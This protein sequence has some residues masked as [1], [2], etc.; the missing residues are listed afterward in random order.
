[1]WLHTDPHAAADAD[2]P[3]HA[4]ASGSAA[5]TPAFFIAPTEP[6]DED[7]AR[8][9]R[10]ARRW[11]TGSLDGY[12]A[13]HGPTT[14]MRPRR[15]IYLSG[16]V[17]EMTRRHAG[18]GD[19]GLLVQP[20]TRSHVPLLPRYGQY[21][22]DNGCFAK[23]EDFDAGAWVAWMATLPLD[24]CLFVVA[25][26]VV[27][28]AA[29]T[30][31]RSRPYLGAI[32]AT[33]QR[34]A[35]VAQDG[36]EETCIEWAAF[37]ALF[38]GGS[39]AWKLSQAAADLADEARRRGKWTHMGRVNSLVRMRYAAEMGLDS[40]DGTFLAFGPEVNGARLLSWLEEL[41]A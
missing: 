20:D 12:E 33:G 30:W 27:G 17:C 1:M 29:A 19:L 7:R 35:L 36:V 26:D 8:M 5:P 39:T 21:A 6:T 32:R 3:T 24:R 25:P 23:G 10:T 38:L 11:V 31:E 37:D 16:V 34:A 15:T 40:V 2:A 41:A 18:R 28:D 9:L 14:Y 4:D 13:V 22:V